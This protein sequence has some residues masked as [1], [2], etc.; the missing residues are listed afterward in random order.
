MAG[1]DTRIPTRSARGP[2]RKGDIRTTAGSGTYPRDHDAIGGAECRDVEEARPS[3]HAG[4][5]LPDALCRS[6]GSRGRPIRSENTDAASLMASAD[7][8]GRTTREKL[9]N[10]NPFLKEL[11]VGDLKNWANR[12]MS[13]Y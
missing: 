12:K 9:I 8:T 2:Q 6:R 5:S 11:T 10:A 13:S 1:D 7:A 4:Y 3:S